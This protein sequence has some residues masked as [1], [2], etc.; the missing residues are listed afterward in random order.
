MNFEDIFNDLFESIQ[1]VE[2]RKPSK[3]PGA[4]AETR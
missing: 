3:L 1:L 2:Q 4:S